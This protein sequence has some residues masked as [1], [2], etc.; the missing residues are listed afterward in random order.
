MTYCKRI[1]FA[2]L[3]ISFLQAETIVCSFSVVKDLCEQLCDGIEELHIEAIVPNSTDP[4]TYQPKPSISKILA[5]ADLII[6]HGLNLEGWLQQLIEASGCACPVVIASKNIKPRYIGNLADPHIWHDPLHVCVMIDNIADALIEAFPQYREHLKSNREKLLQVFK[7]LKMSIE[8]QFSTIKKKQRVMLT[9]HDAFAYFGETFDIKVL[10]PHG[11]STSDDPSAKD[12][13]KIT[14][15][16]REFNISA[17]FLEHLSN[18]A[19]VKVI[20]EETK[21]NIKGTLY[22][23]SL[24]VG[25]HLQDTIWDNALQIAKA[26]QDD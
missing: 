11:V 4:H 26:M 8:K 7:Q 20:A 16:I 24:K 13:A 18:P 22:A 5:K 9:T 10:S 23:D 2:L 12:L 25:L 21:R 3:S 15:Q 19:I 17:I 6:M 14:E 1:L